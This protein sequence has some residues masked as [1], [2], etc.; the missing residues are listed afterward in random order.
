MSTTLHSESDDSSS[1]SSSEY[2]EQIDDDK[3]QPKIPLSTSVFLEKLPKEQY[4]Q[5][6]KTILDH[7][8]QELQP[9]TSKQDQARP[10]LV[11]PR[12]HTQP[13]SAQIQKIT[14]RFQSIGS[15]PSINPKVF[16]ISSSQTI[17]TLSRF[18]SQRLK[19]KG[20]LYL[21]VQNSFS[22]NPD[23]TIGDLFNSFKTNNE[24]II[25]YCYSVAFG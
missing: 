5:L 10:D 3:L 7:E 2:E 19:H 22:P 12:Q 25:S 16:K 18:L 17:S 21:Y 20:L 13:D 4:Q 14:I 23:E 11:S 9:S 24:L 8:N 1:Y 15:T 6:N